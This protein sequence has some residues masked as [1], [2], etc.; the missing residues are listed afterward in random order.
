MTTGPI[1]ARLQ[2][3]SLIGVARESR[4]DDPSDKEN[5]FVEIEESWFVTTTALALLEL[6]KTGSA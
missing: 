6:L 2:R 4:L 1:A 5:D 3:L